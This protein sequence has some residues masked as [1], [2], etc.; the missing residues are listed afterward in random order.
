MGDAL[1]EMLGEQ[2]LERLD[3]DLGR[4]EQHFAHGF[5]AE[6][7]KL[8]THRV[9]GLLEQSLAHEREPVGVHAG[10]RQTNQRVAFGDGRPV[11]DIGLFC[12][13]DGETGKIILVRVIHAGHFGG[14]AADEGAFGL[15]AT[16]GHAGDDLFEQRRVVL[17]A[18]DVVEEEQ[19]FGALGC[20]VVDTHGHAVDADL[21]VLVR[22]LGDHELGAHAVGAGNQHRFAVAEG[23]EIKQATE[24]SDAADHAG[25]ARAGH[26]R[27]DA[28]D[29]LVAGFDTDSCLLIRF[30]HDLP[31]LD[32]LVFVSIVL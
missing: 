23:G 18:R 32:L 1:D 21:I 7:V 26:V 22:H 4:G 8:G 17:A 27:F 2:R 10:G 16:V 24:A 30:W 5:A 28:L 19:R 31:F 6:L 14:F 12:D 9:A 25:T 3:I 13:T 11:D 29:Y 20:N 15:Y